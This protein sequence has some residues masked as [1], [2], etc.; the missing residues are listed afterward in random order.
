MIGVGGTAIAQNLG[1]NMGSPASGVL[2]F[3]QMAAGNVSIRYGLK[4]KSL[5]VVTAC[6][7][8]TNSIGEAFRAVQYG[9]ADV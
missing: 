8:G 1:I 7:T 6:A 4:G 5:N 3:L 2:Q 9:D